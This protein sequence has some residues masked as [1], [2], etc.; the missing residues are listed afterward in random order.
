MMKYILL[1]LAISA[2]NRTSCYKN[3]LV[4][5]TCIKQKIEEIKAQPRWNPPAEI[6][7]YVY[8]ERKVY[9]FS[10]NCCDQYN[11]VYDENCN[12]VCAPSGGFTGK[13]D[14][15]CADFFTK[16]NM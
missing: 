2:W 15:K 7:E 16:A 6:N 9:L 8:E 4:I 12:P 10:S 13:G 1:I 11:V 14:M 5:P 3:R